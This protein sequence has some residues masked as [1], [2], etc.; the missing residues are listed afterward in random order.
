MPIS[1][2]DTTFLIIRQ[3]MSR[4]YQLKIQLMHSKPPIW[5]R[6]LVPATM[7]LSRLHDVIQIAMGWTD[8]HMHQYEL[9]ERIIGIPDPDF[10]FR[11]VE[12][13]RKLTV[14]DVLQREKHRIDYVYDF[15]DD[16]RH[17]ITLEKILPHKPDFPLPLCLKGRGA[18]PPEDIGGMWGYQ[19]FLRI[20]QDP[21]HPEHAEFRDGLPD[22]FDPDAFDLEETN[23][24]LSEYC[25]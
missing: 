15:G 10:D 13:E 4:T 2:L 7:K 25:R 20:L 19:E 22:G 9:G 14:R 17:R 3:N 1:P 18:C 5:R 16:W 23:A 11:E 12:D 6:V 21:E 8:S 24:L